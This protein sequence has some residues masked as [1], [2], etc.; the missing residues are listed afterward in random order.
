M[1]T[2]SDYSGLD[3]ITSVSSPDFTE[4]ERSLILSALAILETRA[5]WDDAVND[6][7]WDVLEDV[8]SEISGKLA[9]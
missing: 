1:L 8:L 4:R 2:W 5:F 6:A 9:P 7:A 3:D